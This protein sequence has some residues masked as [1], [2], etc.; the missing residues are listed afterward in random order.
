[1]ELRNLRTFIRAAELN[2]FSQAAAQLGYAQSTVTAQIDALEQEL[3]VQLFTR[4][5][6]RIR[7][8]TAGADLLQ[9]AYQM[10][11]LED[12]VSGHFSKDSDP[13]GFLHIGILE[14]ISASPYITMISRFLQRYPQV[15][16]KVTIATTLQLMEMLRK[17]GLDLI[18]LFD[19]PIHDPNFRKLYFKKAP[20]LFFAAPN[21]HLFHRSSIRLADLADETWLLTEKGCNYRKLLEDEIARRGLY[22]RDRLEIGSTRAMIDFTAAGLGI[23]LLPAFDLEQALT[24]G[25]VREL[26]L[27]DYS[28][29]MELQLL[30]TK[31]RWLSPVIETFCT[32]TAEL[33][34]LQQIPSKKGR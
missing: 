10:R 1:M 30:I 14:S 8:S 29:E 16:M 20:V 32:E 13:A 31:D 24:G 28:M 3:C 6:R 5:G 19:Q 22:L 23:S 2:S 18:L 33:L 7:L 11:T 34:H 26:P 12:Q 15:E 9:Y 21:H 17:G 25:S 27:A 4:S